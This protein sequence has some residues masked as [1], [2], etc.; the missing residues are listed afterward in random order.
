M[1]HT[2]EDLW[3]LRVAERLGKVSNRRHGGRH[4]AGEH[5]T[6]TDGDIDQT[7]L[8]DCRDPCLDDH[9]RDRKGDRSPFAATQ[10][11]ALDVVMAEAALLA[12][13]V[14]G[15]VT[16]CT[17]L[18]APLTLRLRVVKTSC[19]DSFAAAAVRQAPLRVSKMVAWATEGRP[20]SL[21][22]QRLL[23]TDAGIQN[24]I[25]EGQDIPEH[26]T[27]L[28]F[29]ALDDVNVGVVVLEIDGN[30]V[31]DGCHQTREERA[32]AGQL[33]PLLNKV[34]ARACTLQNIAQR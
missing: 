16:R 4:G 17:R 28:A 12:M 32:D 33:L 34:E 8:R 23:P 14:E 6:G 10:E 13:P 27:Q 29:D 2:C 7:L 21:S 31:V 25:H 20:E 19:S 5:E 26:P 3:A 11:R 15:S 9:L 30:E 24:A 22:F 18:Q 1:I